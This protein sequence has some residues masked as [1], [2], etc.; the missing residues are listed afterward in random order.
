MLTPPTWSLT[1]LSDLPAVVRAC[2]LTGV[3]GVGR[4]AS[5]RGRGTARFPQHQEAVNLISLE[6]VF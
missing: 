5:A 6:L 4:A 2:E 3:H 1:S